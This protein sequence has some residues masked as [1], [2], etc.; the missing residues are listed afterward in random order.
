MII[1][2]SEVST[3]PRTL[4]EDTHKKVVSDQNEAQKNT[5]VVGE[6]PMEVKLP[7]NK[8][9]QSDEASEVVDANMTTEGR[10]E[11]RY[12]TGKR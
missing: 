11:C 12:Q 2:G 3:H 9:A 7:E 5:H 6:T 1:T 8:K 4:T 10:D